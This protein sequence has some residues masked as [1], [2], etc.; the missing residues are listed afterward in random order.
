MLIYAHTAII[1]VIAM[2]ECKRFVN[3][4]PHDVII[5][6]LEG[7]NEIARIPR[8]G[9]VARVSTREEYIGEI[10]GIPIVRI[11][12]GEVENLPEP[13]GETCY[14]VSMLVKQASDREDLL[15]PNTSPGK[16]GAVR[17]EQG[18]IVGVKSLIW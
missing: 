4:T 16:Y 14:I 9:K 2:P 8:S 3:L 1:M 13:D 17:D 15:A 12:Y 10:L 18:R 11:A 7:E 5:Y 6:E